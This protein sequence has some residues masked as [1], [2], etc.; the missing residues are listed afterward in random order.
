[1]SKAFMIKIMKNWQ[2]TTP[3]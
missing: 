2:L 3:P 1:M